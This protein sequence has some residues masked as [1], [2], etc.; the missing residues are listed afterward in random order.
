MNAAK[1]NAPISAARA[2]VI[3]ARKNFAMR[4]SAVTLGQSP[5]LSLIKTGQAGLNSPVG[6]V[7]N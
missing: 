2:M 6:T 1:T 4:S 7:T 5:E 3:R